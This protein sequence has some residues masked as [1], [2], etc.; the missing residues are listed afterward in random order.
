MRSI[1]DK[2]YGGFSVTFSFTGS[3][4]VFEFLNSFLDFLDGFQSVTFKLWYFKLKI[5][6]SSL[7]YIVSKF[8]I[9]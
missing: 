3:G 1:M 6:Y 7:K 2:W 8:K 9:L 4:S 5:K